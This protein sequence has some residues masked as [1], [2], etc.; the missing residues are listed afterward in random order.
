MR[1]VQPRA[2]VLEHQLALL[3]LQRRR[4]GRG[5]QLPPLPGLVAVLKKHPMTTLITHAWIIAVIQ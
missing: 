5:P 4:Q 1:E 3:P 2:L